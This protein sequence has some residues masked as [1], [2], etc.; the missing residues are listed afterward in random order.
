MPALQDGLEALSELDELRNRARQWKEEG[1]A[2]L[3]VVANVRDASWNGWH[4][5][6]A[7]DE[8][9]NPM[10]TRPEWH[11]SGGAIEAAMLVRVQNKARRNDGSPALTLLS[12]L[13]HLT[14]RRDLLELEREDGARRSDVAEVP[15]LLAARAMQSL[16]ASSTDTFSKATMLCYYRII[17][18]IYVAD[19]PDWNAGG[20]R[21][22][23]G[24]E[25]TAYVTGECI[26]AV[27]MLERSF[28]QT[29]EF[30][31]ATDEF[32]RYTR[33]L[34]DGGAV[35][36]WADVESE[37]AGLQW[38]IAMETRQ[39]YLALKLPTLE[40]GKEKRFTLGATEAY[41][42]RLGA[43][44]QKGFA[45]TLIEF[46]E[47][48]KAIGEARG[49]EST[50]ESEGTSSRFI[51]STSAHSVAEGVIENARKKAEK[52]VELCA[53]PL[54]ALQGLGTLAL[55]FEEIAQDIPRLLAPARRYVASVLDHELTSAAQERGL[56]DARELAFAAGAYGALIKPRKDERLARAC[57][58]LINEI[59]DNGIIAPGR[60]FHSVPSGLRWQTL[61]FEACRALCELLQSTE[62]EVTP[63]LVKRMLAPFDYLSIDFDAG[64]GEQAGSSDMF[65]PIDPRAGRRMRGWFMEDP[66]V[67]HRPTLWVTGHAVLALDK[68]VRMLD[69]KINSLILRHFTSK[70][71][72]KIEHRLEGLFYP[73]YGKKLFHAEEPSASPG[74]DEE[75]VATESIGITLQRLRAHI[76]GVKLP[77]GYST[78]LHSCV[79]HGPPGTGKTTLLEALAK[80]CDVPLIQMSPS[81]IVV[82]GEA[83][84]E[85][86]ARATFEALSMLTGVV[87]IFDEFEAI[88]Q[89]RDNVIPGTQPRD[90]V[91]FL[92]PGMLPKLTRLYEEAKKKQV[93]YALVTNH[94]EKIDRAAIRPGRFD[95]SVGIYMPDPVSRAG[96]FMRNLVRSIEENNRQGNAERRSTALKRS[97]VNRFSEIIRGSGGV[98]PARLAQRYLVVKKSLPPGGGNYV[99]EPNSLWKFPLPTMLTLSDEPHLEEKR[100]KAWEE[101]VRLSR[102]SIGRLLE[103]PEDE[104]QTWLKKETQ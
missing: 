71:P 31:R 79:M 24:G 19:S 58:R 52:L 73:D 90:M 4:L 92:T 99:L 8:S 28:K 80:S 100:L 20:A 38:F 22:G 46:T 18:E 35:D 81:D 30:F 87:I 76:L 64:P 77:E 57:D 48:V 33:F 103:S 15:V 65:P 63:A 88:L 2:A 34:R 40:T 6:A 3:N 84:L 29:A 74:V 93:A 49:L 17:R 53:T 101:A 54:A 55:R 23:V 32:Y 36:L 94:I 14:L 51:R 62:L 13:R 67:P 9:G 41:F 85:A 11:G 96:L 95:H 91:S 16:V 89:R 60:P 97:E 70:Q 5:P 37:R 75:T 72:D 78:R 47:A 56:V 39:P 12:R 104:I 26:R 27:L 44:L 68:L 61:H 10:A 50:Q 66:P 21:A 45:D 43:A 86:R 82:Q 98:G 83:A 69:E 1:L 42:D 25:V 59:K 7:L 102:T